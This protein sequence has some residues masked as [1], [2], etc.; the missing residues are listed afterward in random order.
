MQIWLLCVNKIAKHHVI[1]QFNA[2]AT[3]F[4]LKLYSPF[5][6]NTF[7]LNNAVYYYWF[8]LRDTSWRHFIASC[9]SAKYHFTTPC[10]GLSNNYFAPAIDVT[11]IVI[12]MKSHLKLVF[13]NVNL[14]QNFD[15]LS[16]FYR[17]F[18]TKRCLD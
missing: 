16:N 12:N 14:W 5:W 11:I 10:A 8:P 9:C 6:F 18:K 4:C 1:Q 3:V 15:G 2:H 7:W 17:L 13:F